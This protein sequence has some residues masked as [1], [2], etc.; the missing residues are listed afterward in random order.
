MHRTILSWDGE[1][2][3]GS[4]VRAK[5]TIGYDRDIPCLYMVYAI[6]AHQWIYSAKIMMI[7]QSCVRTCM[8]ISLPGRGTSYHPSNC[9]FTQHEYLAGICK[10]YTRHIPIISPLQPSCGPSWSP[11][12]AWM[13][14]TWTFCGSFQF[15]TLK[16]LQLWAGACQSS[17]ASR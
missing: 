10:A 4:Y 8:Y 14:R 13:P 16:V 11:T 15:W 9:I 17:T 3:L 1:A 6:N 12:S 2:L 5:I 7:L